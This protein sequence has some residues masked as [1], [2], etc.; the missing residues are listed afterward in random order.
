MRNIA[1]TKSTWNLRLFSVDVHCPRAAN[2]RGGWDAK[3]STSKTTMFDVFEVGF[4]RSKDLEACVGGDLK[5][6]TVDSICS[7][8][9]G[10]QERTEVRG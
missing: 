9:S 1:N 4:V 3:S 8:V 7:D 10:R 6:L 2:Q 5:L